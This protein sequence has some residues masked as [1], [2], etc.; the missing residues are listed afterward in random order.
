[1]PDDII[2]IGSTPAPENNGTSAPDILITLRLKPTPQGLALN[3]EHD[4]RIFSDTVIDACRRAAAFYERRAI[5]A[6]FAQAMQQTAK[7]Q[8]EI[9]LIKGRG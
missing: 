5:V 1:M 6:E 7:L 2:N 3:V 8:R 4:P 9:G